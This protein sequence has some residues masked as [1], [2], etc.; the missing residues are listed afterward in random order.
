MLNGTSYKS[1]RYL[2]PNTSHNILP[3]SST[4]TSEPFLPYTNNRD[5]KHSVFQYPKTECFEQCY[6]TNPAAL[7]PA[8]HG[9]ERSRGGP[10]PDDS[11]TNMEWLPE[12]SIPYM[13]QVRCKISQEDMKKMPRKRNRNVPSTSGVKACATSYRKPEYSYAMLIFKAINDTEEKRM[14]LFQIYE[15]IENHYLYYKQNPGTHWKSSIRHNLSQHKI[16]VKELPPPSLKSKGSFWA[17]DRRMA[18]KD[19]LLQIQPKRP[20]LSRISNGESACVNGRISKGPYC[21]V[22]P[23]YNPHPNHHQYNL[24]PHRQPLYQ[25]VRNVSRGTQHVQYRQ[26]PQRV[27]NYPNKR[28]EKPGEVHTY[29]NRPNILSKVVRRDEKDTSSPP[30]TSLLNLNQLFHTNNNLENISPGSSS[31]ESGYSSSSLNDTSNN[32]PKPKSFVC[33]TPVKNGVWSSPEFGGFK[34]SPQI[35]SFPLSGEELPN[36]SHYMAPAADPQL[37]SCVKEE[38]K[39]EP[40]GEFWSPT[41]GKHQVFFSPTKGDGKQPR[42]EV[43]GEVTVPF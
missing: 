40:S 31:Y 29:R 34:S 36:L 19:L 26:P 27:Q 3:G 30:G 33:S 14:Q 17:L 12:V 5:N 23:H 24:H 43:E 1:N 9:K 39:V 25:H 35:T 22:L 11:L 20:R 16:F 15:W 38:E 21:A 10:E 42:Y 7:P 13:Q 6:K 2:S 18:E 37:Q 4:T 8:Q 28:E 41:Y 32:S